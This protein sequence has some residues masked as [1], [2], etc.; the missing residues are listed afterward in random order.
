MLLGLVNIVSDVL[1]VTYRI[2]V[3]HIFIRFAS[4][5]TNEVRLLI[6]YGDS[7]TILL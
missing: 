5:R 6:P 3:L 4:A 1:R 7:T 2:L